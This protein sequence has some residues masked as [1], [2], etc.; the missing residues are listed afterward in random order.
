MR[1]KFRWETEVRPSGRPAIG[2]DDR[3]Q[4]VGHVFRHFLPLNG[5][6][7]IHLLSSAVGPSAV[8][9]GQP[10]VD[11]DPGKRRR[12]ANREFHPAPSTA[13]ANQKS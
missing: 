6:R 9:L 5:R 7:E 10:G 13:G 3:D 12:A 2:V 8:R 11:C 1:G 4:C